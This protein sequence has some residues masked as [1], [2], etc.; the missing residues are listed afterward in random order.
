MAID[1]S[2]ESGALLPGY[3]RQLVLRQ[4]AR[5]DPPGRLFW[6]PDP[7][8]LGDYIEHYAQ[9]Q[10]LTELCRCVVETKRGNRLEPVTGAES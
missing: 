1:F 8:V 2:A 9:D 7:Q 6:L 4:V 3:S 10:L 5:G